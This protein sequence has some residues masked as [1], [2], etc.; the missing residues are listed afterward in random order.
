[1]TRVTRTADKKGRVTLPKDFADHLVIIEQVD[2]TEVRIRKAQAIPEKELC[3][4]KNPVAAGMVLHG[5]EDAKAGEFVVG[6]D[7]DAD[8]AG[9]D[10][11]DAED[12]QD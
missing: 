11:T 4:W 8:A 12:T 3:L 5:I 7:I 6:P 10:C 9:L 2:E 1:M